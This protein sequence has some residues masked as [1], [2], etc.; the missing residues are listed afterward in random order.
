MTVQIEMD[1][2][3]P[4]KVL[5]KIQAKGQSVGRNHLGVTQASQFSSQKAKNILGS[6]RN[7]RTNSRVGSDYGSLSRRSAMRPAWSHH[8]FTVFRIISSI[9]AVRIEIFLNLLLQSEKAEFK[10]K[11]ID[12]VGSFIRNRTFKTVVKSIKKDLP[13]L[14][15]Y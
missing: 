8:D 12:F 15:G 1:E 4:R 2:Q 7:S 10:R 9:A 5:K 3:P 11:S 14:F 13:V 6:R